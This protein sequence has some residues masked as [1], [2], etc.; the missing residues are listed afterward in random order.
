V[1]RGTS[2]S[3]V[4]WT[5]ILLA[6]CASHQVVQPMQL[7]AAQARI[8]YFI[9][10]PL[11]GSQQ[12]DASK[13]SLGDALDVRASWFAL[14]QME[15]RSMALVGTQARIITATRAGLAVLPSAGLTSSARIEWADHDS[16][17]SMLDAA[18]RGRKAALSDLRLALPSGVTASLQL[19]DSG[20]VGG[21]SPGN[22]RHRRV[23]INIGRP[24]VAAAAGQAEKL[25]IGIVVED[26]YPQISAKTDAA[27]APAEP[28]VFERET[29]VMDHAIDG[30][31]ATLLMILPFRF[32]SGSTHAVAAI[33]TIS[34]A[35]ADAAFQDAIAQCKKDLQGINGNGQT[36]ATWS[37]GLD[38]VMDSLADPERRRAAMVYLAD[39]SDARICQDVALVADDA[40][41]ASI[42][43]EIERQG[44]GPLDGG[45][46][47]GFSWTLDR[48]TIDA[49]RP[50]LAKAQ[51]PDELFAVLTLHFGEPGRHAA[52]VDELMHGV[53]SRQDLDRRLVEENFIYLQDPSPSQRVRAL[54]WLTARGLAP[55]GYDPMASAKQRRLALDRA[56]S[57]AATTAPAAGGAP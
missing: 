8:T 14:D 7:P 23:E 53:T 24:S 18:N 3:A 4:V 32:S 28:M 41:L 9:G 25:Q 55:A 50:L 16:G 22:S 10:T 6:G 20:G 47:P 54:D 45:D 38:V 36:S 5:A 44:R 39:R 48:C 27:L 37:A 26:F 40:L 13:I 33:V 29:A 43:G 21:E 49:L 15:A 17:K 12:G 11:S 31:P 42:A 46:L 2:L 34:H 52:S 19:V 51:L 1:N 35:K 57:A 56:L 30:Y